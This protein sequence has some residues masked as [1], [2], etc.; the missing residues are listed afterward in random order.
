MF[1]PKFE[2]GG[3]AQ[4]RVRLDASA[5]RPSRGSSPIESSRT[6]R[7]AIAED[8]GREDRAHDR[9][10]EEVL[11]PG[12]GVRAGVDQ[13][14]RPRRDGIGTAIAG[15][16]TPG[17]RRRCMR[18]GGEHRAGVPGRDDRVGA[19]RRPT[20]RTALTSEESGFARTASA[21]FSAISITVGRDDELEAAGVE[22]CRAEE[23]DVDPVGGRRQGP[24]DDL[25]PGRGRRP[26]RRPRRGSRR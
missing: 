15:R 25:A 16:R 5:D 9:E 11:G 4:Q 7:M 19:A 18:P 26:S 6:R 10:L 2:L 20:A 1:P 8:L 22:P 14:R 13:Q 12:V 23:G 17:S 3:L 21:G 24:C